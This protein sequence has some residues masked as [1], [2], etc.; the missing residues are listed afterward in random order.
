[1]ESVSN[2]L[3]SLLAPASAGGM[4]FLQVITALLIA[5]LG[6]ILSSLTP[7]VYPMI[8]ITVSVVGGMGPDRRSWK[9]IWLRGAAYV[10]GMTVIYSFLGVAAGLT[11]KV[12]GTLTNT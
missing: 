9:E 5:Y 11:G 4:S 12:F 2:F 8:P 3:N 10:G 6:G 1:M 7:C